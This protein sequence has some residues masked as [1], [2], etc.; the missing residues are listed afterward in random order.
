MSAVR[1]LIIVP[2]RCLSGGGGDVVED[3][4]IVT[5]LNE[6]RLEPDAQFVNYPGASVRIALATSNYY[7]KVNAG[8]VV[9]NV[10]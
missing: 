10:A 7:F 8:D 9:E 4:A 1:E 2:A 3:V 5:F 6:L